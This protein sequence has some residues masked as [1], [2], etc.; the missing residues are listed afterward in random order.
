MATRNDIIKQAQAWVGKNEK[1]GSFKVIIDTYNTQTKL[2][3]G[4]KMRYTDEWCAAF[5]TSLAIACKATDII[6][7]ECSCSKLIE[8][9]KS[10]GCWVEADNYVPA[11]GDFIFYDWQ[12]TTGSS[13]DNVGSV[14]HIGVVEKVSNGVITVIEGNKGE[15]VARRS[16]AVNG[17]YIRGFGVPKYA[18][19]AVNAVVKVKVELTQ[20]SKGSKGVQV[21]TLQRLLNAL[22]YSCGSVD[23]DFGTK[24]NAAV[25]KFQKAKGLA[26]DGV[27]GAKTWAALLN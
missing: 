10:M 9:Y 2:P 16:V 18:A 4:Y 25:L 7:C 15:A 17:K 1:D 6:P 20:L 19:A 26:A 22:G 24:T 12:D 13:K 21:K 8:L 11:A 5:A 3:R 23:G 27:V 14:E